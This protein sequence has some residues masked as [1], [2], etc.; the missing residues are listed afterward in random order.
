MK[1]NAERAALLAD[2][3]KIDPNGTWTDE[4]SAAEGLPPCRLSE[5]RAA[6]KKFR[7]DLYPS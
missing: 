7:Q 4:A 2:L 3:Q 6:L 5:A 1:K